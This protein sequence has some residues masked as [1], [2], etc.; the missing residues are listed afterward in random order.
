MRNILIIYPHKDEA[1]TSVVEVMKYLSL[2]YGHLRDKF[3]IKEV[4]VRKKEV[5]KFTTSILSADIVVVVDHSAETFMTLAHCRKNLGA[6]FRAIFYVLGMAPMGLW[7]LFKFKL[8]ELLTNHD[9][10]I[11]SCSRDK[12]ILEENLE[13]ANVHL[14]RFCIENDKKKFLFSNSNQVKDLL[15]IGRLTFQKNIHGLIELLSRLKDCRLTLVGGYDKSITPQIINKDF[16]YESLI[17]EK[18]AQLKLEDR[19]TFL[20]HQTQDDLDK[21]IKSREYTYICLSHNLD[22]NFNL[23]AFRCISGGL[24]C[25]MTNWGGQ[26][27]FKINF[28]NNVELIDFSFDENGPI[29]NFDDVSKK[30][31][32][33]K[34]SKNTYENA[35]YNIKAQ[36]EKIAQMLLEKS[37]SEKN[38]VKSTFFDRI[39][40]NREELLKID[41]SGEKI[42]SG[43]GDELYLK[44]FSYYSGKN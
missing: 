5:L 35:D 44:M 3:S 21:I 15:Y 14:F 39:M 28:T 16:D 7:S 37:S 23:S 20:G 9:F 29:V 11:V 30:I 42:F 26:F 31:E 19:I 17:L 2:K 18:I 22:E 34:F 33:I 36:S 40:V 4:F 8:G 12:K 13:N 25:I 32:N 43:Y 10:F 27:D 41:N 6:E 38:V 1:T 24:N